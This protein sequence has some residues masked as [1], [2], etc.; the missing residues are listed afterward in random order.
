LHIA[1]ANASR[2]HPSA[3]AAQALNYFALRPAGDINNAAKLMQGQISVR[4]RF[5]GSFPDKSN[6]CTRGKFT[7]IGHD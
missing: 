1:A 7:R 5:K 4:L 2:G 6:A 3:A